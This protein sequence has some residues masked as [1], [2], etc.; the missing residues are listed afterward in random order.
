[1]IAIEKFI[2]SAAFDPYQCG[3]RNALILNAGVCSETDCGFIGTRN[4]FRC[5]FQRGMIP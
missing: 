2:F 4:A 5:Q 3:A 1:V